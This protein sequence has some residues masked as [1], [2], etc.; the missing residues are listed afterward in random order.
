MKKTFIKLIALCLLCCVGLTSCLTTTPNQPEDPEDLPLDDPIVR[1]NDPS[2]D[3]PEQPDDPQNPDVPQNPDIPGHNPPVQNDELRVLFL[4]NS[5]MFFNDMPSLFRD[6]A[7]RA[8][9]KVYVDSVTRGS[10]TISDFAHSFTDV[11]SQAYPKLQN[12]RWDYVIIEPS[13]RITPYERTT[14]EAELA[15]AKV[16]QKMAADA[17]A[18]ILLYCVWGNNDG[19]LTEYN[20]S[21]PTAMIKGTVHYDYTRKMH[22]EFLKKVNTEFSEALGGVGVIDAGYAFENSI[23]TYPNIN[24]YD[25]DRRHPSLEGSYLAAACVYATIYNESP[26]NIGFTGG[27][28]LYFEMQR[29]AKMTVIDKLVPDLEEKPEE[30]VQV[31]DPTVYDILFIG[32]DLID[33]YDI[34]TSLESMIS[35]GQDLKLNL[36]FITNSTGVFNKL[37]QKNTDFGM[38][39]ALSRVK[40]DAVILQVSRRCTPSATDVEASELAALKVIY[41]II[42]EN[43]DNIY[44]YTFNGQSNPSIFTTASDPV[45]YSKTDRKESASIAKM[46]EYYTNIAQSWAQEVG[47][48]VIIQGKAWSEASPAT[49][50]AKGY[51]RAC[52]LY[53]SIFEESVPEGINTNGV[54]ETVASNIEKITEKYC[55]PEIEVEPTPVPEYDTYDVLI[56]G[57]KLLDN[58][59]AV[60]PLSNMI[61]AGQGKELHLQYVTNSVGVLNKLAQMDTSDNFYS[62]YA[63]A[64]KERK[65]DAVIIQISRRITPTGADVEASELAALKD[66]YGDISQNCS[67]IYL[68]TLIGAD[69]AA[70]FSTNAGEIEYTKTSSKETITAA[71][72]TEYYTSVANSWATEL[73]CKVIDQGKIRIIASPENDAERGYMRA[74]CYYNALFGEVIPT[75]ASTGGLSEDRAKAMSKVAAQILLGILPTDMTALNE[76]IAQAEQKDENRY[77]P[78]S[79]VAFKEALANAKA[80][81][82]EATQNEVDLAA[83]ALNKAISA[84]VERADF[85]K[86]NSAIADA[87]SKIKANYTDASWADL[88]AM[89]ANAEA[90]D[91]NANQEEVNLAAY[92]LNQAIELL[93]VKADLTALNAA[94]ALAESKDQNLYTVAYW[95]G[96][97]IALASARSLNEN[98]STEEVANATMALNE[99]IVALIEKADLTELNSI[100]ASANELN[101]DEYLEEGWNFLQSTIA[102]AQ[103]LT[104]ESAQADVDAAIKAI[105][106]AIDALEPVPQEPT[107]PEY[108]TYDVLF[109]GSNLINDEYIFPSLSSMISLGQGKEL[110][111][112]YINDGVGVINRLANHDEISSEN[113][114]YVQ[115][116]EA[117]VERRWDAIIIQFSRR[118]TPGSNVVESELN[119][120][121]SIYPMLTENTSN[122]YIFTLNGSAN[123]DVF[124]T[125]SIAYDKT[126]ESITA[127]AKEI[128][129]FYRTTIESWSAELGCKGIYYG[130]S[131][132]DG[133]QPSTSKPKGF[134]RA[135]CIYY[136]IFGEEMPTGT[137]VQGTSS[138]GVKKI[139]EAVA[140]YCLNK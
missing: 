33:S 104:A 117:L 93:V 36:T 49:D 39:D 41:P 88:E 56:I 38:R 110:Y 46:D 8:G 133:F 16:L 136:S 105:K 106:D 28:P 17:G 54:D 126:G 43:T 82:D 132:D 127:T 76:A 90:L 118:C 37:A 129:D 77:T 25:S 34:T 2:T 89:L 69:S 83:E 73:G 15:S 109:V 11:G 85:T 61:S 67:N 101:K 134:M 40:Y 52:T 113:D 62:S 137:N 139:Q 12:E 21:N 95:A 99:A 87:K 97:E 114:V 59:D 19:T 22:V 107:L 122:I 5:L 26:E 123:P 71:E 31:D 65:W 138:S 24:L 14:Y 4:G 100:I 84:L 130:S 135:L 128:S 50:A 60:T 23:V 51:L 45:N 111:L 64:L 91:A 18:K 103:D 121:R 131:Y 116:R 115:L 81:N 53:N 74:C 140:K 30:I 32:S 55:L 48:K 66:I 125:G 44:L 20:A 96:L 9:K 72:M 94:I 70:I 47:C 63:S 6:L 92:K 86:L 13:R 58:C 108:D 120:L 29:I 68:I 112:N 27:T 3:N 79:L 124:T 78:N 7:Q 102:K 80:L 57:S 42:C 35:A 10:A 1:P 98:S 119:A 75:G